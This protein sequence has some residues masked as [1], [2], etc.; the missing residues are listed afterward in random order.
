VGLHRTIIRDCDALGRLLELNLYINVRQNKHP[1]FT[2]AVVTNFY[3]RLNE[4]LTYK[5]PPLRDTEGNDEAEVHIKAIDDAVERYPHFLK[6]DNSTR[7]LLF[8]P[9]NHFNEGRLF[10][11]TIMVKEKN[12]DT[13]KKPYYCSVKV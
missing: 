8:R 5:L 7:T 12:S 6:F 3:V 10:Y 1:D 2:T 4:V 11:F 13:V 9:I